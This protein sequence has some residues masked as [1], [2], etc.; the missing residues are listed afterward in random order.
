M[1]YVFVVCDSEGSVM[2]DTSTPYFEETSDQDIMPK[3]FGV[4]PYSYEASRETAAA[5]LSQH[6]SSE[7]S[8]D[9]RRRLK[10][11]WYLCMPT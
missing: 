1:R 2:S 9:A 3:F 7:R 10:T 11:K 6:S 4:Y 8:A 5:E